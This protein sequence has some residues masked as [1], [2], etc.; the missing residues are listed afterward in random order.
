VNF[1]H[2][3]IRTAEQATAFFAH[4]ILLN[5][6]SNT[7]ITNPPRAGWFQQMPAAKSAWTKTALFRG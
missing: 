5:L 7:L 4:A 3:R 6:V 1:R 2:A